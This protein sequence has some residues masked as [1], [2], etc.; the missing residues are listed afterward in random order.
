MSSKLGQGMDVVNPYL[1]I[2]NQGHPGS[3]ADD[4]EVIRNLNEFTPKKDAHMD[5]ADNQENLHH[6]S[7][8]SRSPF[9]PI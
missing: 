7:K 4:G 8:V 1:E 9:P 3:K 2:L 5:D 6:E